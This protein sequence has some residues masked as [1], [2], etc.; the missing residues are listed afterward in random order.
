MGKF[1][2]YLFSKLHLI[3]SK[4]EGPSYF[5]QQ[6]SYNEIPVVK[7]TM[8]WEEDPV[9]HKYLAKEVMIEGKLHSNRIYY[10]KIR[11]LKRRTAE[12]PENKLK[13]DLK[14]EGLD[15][16]ILWVNKQPSP[17]PSVE[18][19]MGLILLVK[20]PYRSVWHGLCPT[21]Q[22]YDFFIEKEDMIIWK[23][24][25][26]KAF[27]MVLTPV[28]VPGGDF[29]TFPV[30]WYFSPDEIEHE[31]TYTVCAIFIASG[32]EICKDFEIKF[33]H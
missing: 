18:Q 30:T 9:L 15:K 7:K 6:W 12:E 1:E 27:N 25:E 26:G 23:W 31:D 28:W 20:W 10:E 21:S 16:N 24:S 4:S 33:A 29:I 13:L 5:L 14:F 17:G 2:G 19:S 8:L 22:I 11:E 3:G 32:Q